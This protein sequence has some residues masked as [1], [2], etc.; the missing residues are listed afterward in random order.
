MDQLT[1]LKR[2]LRCFQLISGLRI[3][4]GK[5]FLVGLNVDSNILSLSANCM[6][7]KIESLPIKY[8]GLPLSNKRLTVEDWKMVSERAKKR[9]YLWHGSLLSSAEDLH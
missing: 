2:V 5:G 9:L 7:R 3:N 6:G 8:L 1:N 4:F